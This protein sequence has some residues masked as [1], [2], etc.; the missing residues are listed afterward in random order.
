MA[1][2]PLKLKRER[3]K[4]VVR[5]ARF[6]TSAQ[7]LIDHD[8]NHLDQ[9]FTYG[10]PDDLKEKVLV[11]SRVV[12]PFKNEEREGI[13]LELIENQLSPNKPII[14]T[15]NQ[16]SY[17]ADALKFAGEVASRYASSVVKILRY[18]P[19]GRG[20]EQYG[21]V[22]DREHRTERSFEQ[23]S[24][25]TR[26]KLR[27]LLFQQSKGTLIL[28]PSEREA[29]QL[30]D[31]LEESFSARI[32]KAFAR[33]KPP[34][35]FPLAPIVVG[36]RAAIFWQIPHLSSI[37]IFHENSEHYWSDRSPFWNVRDVALIRSRLEALNL[38]FISGFPSMEIARLLDIG[39]L[40]HIKS[41]RK[42]LLQRRRVRSKPDTYHQ[43]IR[44][45]LKAGVVL[46][47]VAT[48]DY[49]TL[50]T[51]KNCRSRP[52]CECGF[53]LK[54]AEKNE[55]LCT[56]CG[57]STLEWRCNTCG[58]K[59]KLLLS[60][61]ARRIE[62]ELGKAFPATPI[63]IST[64]N[65]E[66]EETPDSGI[67]IATP[68][69]EPKGNKFAA[70]VLLDGELQ[71]NRPT[72]RAEERLLDNWFTLLR[73]IRDDASIFID[74]GHNSRVVQS[75]ISDSPLRLAKALLVERENVKLP[76]WYRVVKIEGEELGS[77]QEQIKLKFPNIEVSKS[78]LS[79]EYVL[80]IPVEE[81][82]E[83]I[84]GIHALAKYRSASRKALISVAIDPP[85]L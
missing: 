38:H 26:E 69:M 2:K 54:M 57:F 64:S 29:S 16:S 19:E 43:T 75:I 51:C 58:G 30:F 50:V 17:S 76:P 68:G 15:M 13:V 34:K 5:S 36:T 82:E 65:K 10:L 48:K 9:P 49:A 20:R 80:R 47:Q 46:V 31:E 66:L 61:G 81:S 32:V 71:L 25:S 1:A 72:L 24:S 35:S 28:V 4:T 21:G 12:V 55:L 33:S 74:L 78:K 27:E 6:T 3:A 56:A 41:P 8:I 23:A 11:G 85:D 45:G 44:E 79:D 59:E 40:R 18:I 73:S 39:Y 42:S 62:E 53:Y 60:R 52:T 67:V 70:L 22:S 7:V 84:Q 14:R 77:L 37:V 63:H 83:V